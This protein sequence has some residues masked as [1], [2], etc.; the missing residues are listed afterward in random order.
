[1]LFVKQNLIPFTPKSVSK[2]E[3]KKNPHRKENKLRRKRGYPTATNVGDAAEKHRQRWWC[4]AS[5]SLATAGL[6]R[7]RKERDLKR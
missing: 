3:E 4:W 5:R 1:M 6:E 2:Q 7:T